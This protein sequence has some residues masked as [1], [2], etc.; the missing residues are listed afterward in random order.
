MNYIEVIVPGEPIGAPRM[1]QR[2]KWMKRP[3]VVRYN[4]WREAA[5]LAMIA[6]G[7]KNAPDEIEVFAWLM[8][9]KT[10]NA[11]KRAEH[12]GQFAKE[13]KPDV[14]N[15]LKAVLD[16]FGEDK[17][18]GRALVIKRWVA[19]NPRVVLRLIYR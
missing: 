17:G 13:R 15:I 16:C 8:M 9:P 3:V 7:V 1:T 19:L 18:V 4:D 11:E 12:D 5:R 2:D 14:D 6:A 10:W